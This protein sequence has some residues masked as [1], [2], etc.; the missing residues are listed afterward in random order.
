M[1]VLFA[2]TI[3][4]SSFM[5]FLVQPLIAKQI[6]P[7]FGG[8]AAVWTTCL[9]FF[10]SLLLAGYAYAH[11]SL[12]VLRPRARTILHVALLAVSVAMLPVIA[13]ATWKPTGD[14]EPVLRILL[15]LGATIG[16]PYFMLSSTGPLVQVWYFNALKRIPYRLFS[17]SNI[18]SLLALVLYPVAIE[19]WVSTRVQAIA[20]SAAF[21]AFVLLCSSSAVIGYRAARGPR[22]VAEPAAARQGPAPRPRDYLRWMAL[23]ALASYMLLAVSNHIAQNVASIPFLWIP[24]LVLYLLSFILCF[25][26][27]GWYW[28]RVYQ[29]L[30]VAA[31]GGMA[32]L[33]DSL[34]LKVAIP[35][36]LAGLFVV[37]MFCHGEIARQRPSADHLTGY[38]LMISL[39]GVLGGLLVAVLAPLLFNGYFELGVG[40]AGCA[41]IA[42]VR[43]SA[44]NKWWKLVFVPALAYACYSEY[45]Q[46]QEYGRGALLT[47]RDFYGA[48]RVFKNRVFNNQY[49]DSDVVTLRHG[50]ILHGAQW[51]EPPDKRRL[52]VTYY[53]PRSGLGVVLAALH[54]ESPRRLG[55]VGL[56]A[57]TLAAYGKAGD[58]VRFYEINPQVVSIARSRFHYLDESAAH[59]E[60]AVGDA[61]L[62][63]ER[64]PAQRFDLLAIDAFSGD[65]IPVH[66]LSAEALDLYLRHLRPDGAIL[67]HVTNRY[68]RLAPVVA[69]LAASRGLR[70]GLIS[71]DPT[72]AQEAELYYRSSDWVVVTRNEALLSLPSVAAVVKPIEVSDAT[73]LWTDDFNNLVSILK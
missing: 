58:T 14:E 51:V 4:L 21:A 13:S 45:G 50:G 26:H 24:P 44:G 19:P 43:R 17:L 16:L 27:D 29:L 46:I 28:P 6:L 42:L 72:F 22:G 18:G 41:L 69:K 71:D 48:L 25:D 9:L 68:L 12:R 2:G 47:E 7:W 65:A 1:P 39:G 73:P 33:L 49:G 70:A 20:W 34:D 61:R 5:L 35:A 60:V 53:G 36:Y 23:A 64:E 57:G 62:S 10:Q 8:A 38:Y 59:I 32:W 52:P 63:L 56:G 37:C 3:F 66:L 11:A 54:P 30:L 31:I 67:F 40:L 55:M 15:L